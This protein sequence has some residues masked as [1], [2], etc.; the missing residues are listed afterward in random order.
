MTTTHWL[1][2][3]LTMGVGKYVITSPK[4]VQI[5]V[6]NLHSEFLLHFQKQREVWV[7]KLTST[8]ETKLIKESQKYSHSSCKKLARVR[9]QRLGLHRI[10]GYEVC[11]GTIL[12]RQFWATMAINIWVS[13]KY[14]NAIPFLMGDFTTITFTCS[15]ILKTSLISWMRALAILLMWSKPLQNTRLHINALSFNICFQ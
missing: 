15:P 8:Q 6:Q 12:M 11:R 14:L 2:Q 4:S 9:F 5:I 10:P 3:L 1:H 7:M 13:D